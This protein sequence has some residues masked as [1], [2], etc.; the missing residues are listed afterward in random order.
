MNPGTTSNTSLRTFAW[1]L[2]LRGAPARAKWSWELRCRLDQVGWFLHVSPKL[3][4]KIPKSRTMESSEKSSVKKMIVPFG[5]DR[6]VKPGQPW[7]C[8]PHCWGHWLQ[9]RRWMKHWVTYLGPSFHPPRG[10][11]TYVRTHVR[12]YRTYV[13]TYLPTYLRT[14]VSTYARTHVP[15]VHTYMHASIHPYIHTSIHTCMRIGD[16]DLSKSD[17]PGDDFQRW[18]GL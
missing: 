17:H 5:P 1:K 14:Y 15:C 10:H 4:A 2:R 9:K 11:S 18:L 13:H 7:S 16:Q 6:G 8:W 12:T 3:L